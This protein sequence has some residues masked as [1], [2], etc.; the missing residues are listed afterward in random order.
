MPMRKN[1]SKAQIFSCVVCESPI[2]ERWA[3]AATNTFCSHLCQQRQKRDLYIS[4]WKNGENDGNVSKGTSGYIKSYIKEKF[5]NTCQCCGI[6][7]WNGQSI[8]LTVDHIDGDAYNSKE[9]NLNLLCPNCH[10][11]TPTYAGRNKGKGT[12]LYRKK[13]D[14]KYRDIKAG[15]AQR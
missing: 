13:Y 9:E 4:A 15:L 12:R 5:S 3:T 8:T 10:S 14:D 7:E 11:Q 2:R 6:T 1:A